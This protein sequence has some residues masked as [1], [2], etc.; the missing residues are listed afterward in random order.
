MEQL[1][2]LNNKNK[3]YRVAFGT[4]NG[5]RPEFGRKLKLAATGNEKVAAGF[6]LRMLMQV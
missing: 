6:S 2:W 3:N 4:V 5:A 1:F